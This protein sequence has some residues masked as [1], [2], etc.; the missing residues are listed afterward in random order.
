[1]M[2]RCAIPWLR[3]VTH[4]RAVLQHFPEKVDTA[5]AD[6][7]EKGPIRTRLMAA[8]DAAGDL[9]GASSVICRRL[10]R[11]PE[12]A[13]IEVVLGYAAL[14][15]EVSIDDT[16][17]RLIAAGGTVCL[18][19]V[20]GAELGVGVVEDLDADLAPGWRGVREP[21][22][23]LRRPL[24]PQAL[25]ALI[26]PGVGFDLAGNRLGYGGGHFDRLLARTRRGAVVIGVALDEQIVDALPVE[27][28]DRA[29]DVVVTPTRTIRPERS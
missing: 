10:D 18:P 6:Q 14:A 4:C 24:R 20:N 9:A 13:G 2:T 15:R 1:M 26:V 3:Q 16:L 21:T 8:R 22:P 11:L 27:R 28:H 17:R 29:V 5:L 19:W 7:R 12:L 25:D 23:D